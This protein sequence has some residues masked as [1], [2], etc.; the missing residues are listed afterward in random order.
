[1][2]EAARAHEELA[3]EGLEFL[4][5][6]EPGMEWANFLDRT[7]R[8]RH[9]IALSETQ[10]PETFLV[11]E[12]GG[13]LVGRVSI[14]HH[15]NPA[16]RLVGGHIGYSVRPGFRRN[17][18]AGQILDLALIEARNLGICEALLTCDADNLASRRLIE[19]HDGVPE[20]LNSQETVT[21][22]KLRY[23]ITT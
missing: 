5:G 10:V 17:G 15:L 1:M 9:G 12:I 3:G 20:V 21:K 4:L 16:L 6:Y 18:F 8:L 22:P 13:Q 11:A 14:R 23:W 7:E 19:S 2:H